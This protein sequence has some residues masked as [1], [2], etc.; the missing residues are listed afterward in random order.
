MICPRIAGESFTTTDD[1][2]LRRPMQRAVSRCEAVVLI[3]LLFNVTL[4][5]LAIIYSALL[6]LRE[7]FKLV[8]AV[9]SRTNRIVRVTC[10][11]ALCEDIFYA[12]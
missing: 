11:D 4:N 6:L 8:E 1:P 12:D 10:A 2:V 7:S 9:E 5:C 3:K